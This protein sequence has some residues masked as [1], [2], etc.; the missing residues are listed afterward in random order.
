MPSRTKR[1]A[2][3]MAAFAVELIDHSVSGPMMIESP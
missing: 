1:V 2:A 3:N